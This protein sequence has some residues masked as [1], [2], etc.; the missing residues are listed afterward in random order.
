MTSR[1]GKRQFPAPKGRKTRSRI[2]IDPSDFVLM[3]HR[4]FL[5]VT[6]TARLLDVDYKTVSNWEKGKARIPYTAYRVLKLKVGYVFDDEYFGEWFTRGNILWSP[7]GRA[8]Y[9]HELRYIGSYFWMARQWL[10]DRQAKNQQRAE[11]PTGAASDVS[12]AL[13][14]SPAMP[15]KTGARTSSG[16]RPRRDADAVKATLLGI[17]GKPADFEKFLERLGIPA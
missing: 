3:R 7:E 15:G 14:A 17:Q 10:A 16:A 1:S 11:I 13:P 6:K 4:A 2:Y 5:T 8:F 12:P 9:A